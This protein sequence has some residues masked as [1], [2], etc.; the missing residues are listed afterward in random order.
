MGSSIRV[1]W[2]LK[3]L[4]IIVLSET[5]NILRNLHTHKKKIGMPPEIY[6]RFMY[7]APSNDHSLSTLTLPVKVI[8][9]KF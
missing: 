9:R 2:I 8:L 5:I 4:W 1:L 3:A 7:K 6:H